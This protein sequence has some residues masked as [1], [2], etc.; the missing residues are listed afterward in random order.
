[1]KALCYRGPR[2]IVCETMT[3]AAVQADTDAIVKMTACGICGS[4]LH[5]YHGEGFSPE[6]G[7]CVG[8]EAIG[9]IVETG[10]GVR[11]LKP[12]DKVMLSAA[13]GCGAC[14][15]CLA[16]RVT[17]C[18][19]GMMACYGLG[20]NLQ[21]CQ[22]EAIR[23]PHADLNAAPIPDGISDDQAL[24]LT[25]NLPTAWFACRQAGIGPGKTVVVVGLG[26]IGLMAVEGALVMGAAR[27]FAV[28]LVA[29]RRAIGETLGA[30]A[31]D[32]SVAA[33]TIMDETRG[34]MADCA[35]ECVGAD[36]TIRQAI[37]YVGRFGTVSVIGVNHNQQFNFPMGLAFFK[38]LN[39]RIG[40]CSVPEHWPE[41]VPLIR[42]GRLH[43]ERTITHRL[44]LDEGERAY[45]IFDG[46]R[47]G[48]LKVVMT[49]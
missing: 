29:E 23:V 37:D 49:P 46:R 2:Q 3:D 1:M 16:G 33:Q 9:E 10:R 31:R 26:P 38:G 13:V 39:F 47:D 42:S 36:A 32:P 41:L 12:G 5:I 8:H 4:D 45:A 20:P 25:D 24:M 21:G 27:V 6:L 44:T 19:T 43:P 22:A 14:R 11:R 30:T 40:C 17:T 35:V 7:Y 48:A 28:D 34:M 18:L 15:E